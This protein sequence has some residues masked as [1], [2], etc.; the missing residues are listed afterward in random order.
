M[1]AAITYAQAGAQALAE[2]MRADP[3]VWALGEDLSTAI[4]GYVDV[5]AAAFATARRARI[6]ETTA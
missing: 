5:L 2:A 6:S 1:S 4:G 3:H